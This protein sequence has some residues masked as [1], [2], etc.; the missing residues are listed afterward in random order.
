MFFCFKVLLENRKL[1]LEINLVLIIIFIPFLPNILPFMK[2]EPNFVCARET[3]V[4]TSE[5]FFNQDFS[6]ISKESFFFKCTREEIC[7]GDNITLNSEIQYFSFVANYFKIITVEN[8]NLKLQINC[9]EIENSSLNSFYVFYTIGII[10][11]STFEEKYIN[12]KFLKYFI[13]ILLSLL[14]NFVFLVLINFGKLNILKPFS[15][16]F[17]IF[18]I[19]LGIY[20][21]L[22]TKLSISQY[23]NLKGQEER[24]YFL[25]YLNSHLDSKNL[26]NI[27]SFE[28]NFYSSISSLLQILIFYYY[29][30]WIYNFS[31]F[32]IVS[33]INLLIFFF[34][35]ILE[36]K[37]NRIIKKKFCSNIHGSDFQ[38]FTPYSSRDS[39]ICIDTENLNFD[40]MV[41][42]QTKEKINNI[43]AF[44]N[45]HNL[46]EINSLYPDNNLQ[47]ENIF[48]INKNKKYNKN[49]SD[50]Q[51]PI[52]LPKN[53]ID[54]P[55]IVPVHNMPYLNTFKNK[56]SILS[57][58][59]TINQTLLSSRTNRNHYYSYLDSNPFSKKKQK[60]K[61][62]KFKKF[63][64]MISCKNSFN[65]INICIYIMV[66]I[67]IQFSNFYIDKFSYF[68]F[69]GN[70][71][72]FFLNAVILYVA[73]I[74]SFITFDSFCRKFLGN[75]KNMNT[76]KQPYA[77]L[78]LILIL[79]LSSTIIQ[80]ALVSLNNE[81]LLIFLTVHKFATV[82][83]TLIV[84]LKLENTQDVLM[85]KNRRKISNT[86]RIS[87]FI[88]YFIIINFQNS[89]LLL[90]SL[91]YICFLV[92]VK[93]NL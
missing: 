6:S 59:L 79:A 65:F 40:Y 27:Q 11:S 76:N 82:Y 38:K 68:H 45:I 66:N 21:Y 42:I 34:V 83:L 86:S 52:P 93:I 71:S 36:E 72:N 22:I 77:E 17:A 33:I 15:L 26:V 60:N 56:V 55:K 61:F 70:F 32:A 78:C 69:S 5:I 88:T 12:S 35:H 28:L 43:K 7:G 75:F 30:N 91:Y 25:V 46:K 9:K 90:A 89:F 37:E 1:L 64:K 10:I 58:K 80:V 50:I 44:I 39:C 31:I 54:E 18:S 24:K 14:L 20:Y 48:R 23:I 92:I 63:L 29:K 73:E 81:L 51:L 41:K 13:L 4:S 3:I 47:N 74:L 8:S 85:F 84:V 16:G 49:I 53:L 87:V 62:L 57:N 2:I 67:S 19:N